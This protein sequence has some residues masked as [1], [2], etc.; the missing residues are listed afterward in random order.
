MAGIEPHEDWHD[1]VVGAGTAGA[2]LAARLSE[3]PRRRVLLVEAGRDPAAGRMPNVLGV[4]VVSGYNWDYRA[5]VE[6]GDRARWS[7][8]PLGRVVGGTSA[9][10]GAI[11]LRALPGDFD[12][13]A[14]AGN[15]EWA[16]DRVLPVYAA[17]ESDADAKGPGHGTD[18]PVPIRRAQPHELGPMAAAFLGSCHAAGL[19]GIDDFNDGPHAGAGAIPVNGAAGR[20]MSSADTHLAAARG[21]PNLTVLEGCQGRRVIL[22]GDRAVGVEVRHEG[23]VRRVRARRV[24]LAAGGVGTP[25][26]LQRSGIGDP[27]R[28]E[29]IDIRTLIGLPGVG[30]GL[31]D[32]PAV[33]LWLL[34]EPG[35][36]RAGDPWYEVMARGASG[37]GGDPDFLLVLAANIETAA[38]PEA[39]AALGGRLAAMVSAVLLDPHSRG[40]VFLDGGGPDASPVITLDLLS[41]PRDVERMMRAVRVAWSVVRSAPFTDTARRVMVW[42]DRM[43]R[44]DAL[45]EQMVRRWSVPL[46]HAAGTARM[47][48]AS[49][50]GAVVDERC[51]VHGVSGLVVCD[52]SVMPAPVSAP[53]SLT[54]V[55]LAERVAAWLR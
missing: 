37:P 25:A 17:L 48:P 12:R 36:C 34:P 14:A 38:L 11:A 10:N 29:S 26:I 42:T 39:G 6:S 30:D 24:I 32:H 15:P 13:W 22:D 7:P 2:V 53:P 45:L 51:R 9:V 16:W 5:R 44:E 28:L 1:I 33:P 27:R 43:V 50:P 3:E 31:I 40:T 21:R 20:R 54:C 23:R 55:M 4:P 8:Y 46:F 49:D 19:A 35:A 52:A 47:G 41:A 18:G